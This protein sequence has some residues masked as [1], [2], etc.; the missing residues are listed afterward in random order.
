MARDQVV[1]ASAHL[2]AALGGGVVGWCGAH[3]SAYLPL[4]L[5]YVTTNRPLGLLLATVVAAL[6]PFLATFARGKQAAKVR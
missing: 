4:P 1:M 2:G 6:P 3:S 5:C